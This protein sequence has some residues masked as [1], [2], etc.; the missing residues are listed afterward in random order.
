MWDLVECLRWSH[1]VKARGSP[2]SLASCC[3]GHV[4]GGEYALM[5]R[6][7]FPTYASVYESAYRASADDRFSQ[8]ILDGPAPTRSL[9]QNLRW[10]RHTFRVVSTQSI[11]RHL[12]VTS[13]VF[14]MRLANVFSKTVRRLLIV[15]QHSL[16]EHLWRPSGTLVT[17]LSKDVDAMFKSLQGR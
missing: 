2:V 12:D 13:R 5:S 17:L 11:G 1:H 8:W 6:H 14:I 3:T 15:L 10:L 9:S 16:L 7:C 4:G